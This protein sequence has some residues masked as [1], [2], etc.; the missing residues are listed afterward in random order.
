MDELLHARET[1]GYHAAIRRHG[2]KA[3]SFFKRNPPDTAEKRRA[4][5]LAYKAER[6]IE[7]EAKRR[8]LFELFEKYPSRP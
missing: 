5:V 8:R 2:Q 3:E 4:Y 6:R 1:L 7:R